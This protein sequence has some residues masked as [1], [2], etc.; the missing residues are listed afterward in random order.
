MACEFPDEFQGGLRVTGFD[1]YVQQQRLA[2][3]DF[4]IAG[5]AM[6]VLQAKVGNPVTDVQCF[7]SLGSPLAVNFWCQITAC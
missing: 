4:D 5:L 2:G 3:I 6:H 7:Y 1:D